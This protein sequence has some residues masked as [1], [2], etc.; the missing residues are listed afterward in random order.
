MRDLDLL[1]DFEFRIERD[2]FVSLHSLAQGI[3]DGGVDCR[4]SIPKL[5]Q[6]TDTRCMLDTPPFSDV[7][8]LGKEVAGKHCLHKPDRA[9]PCQF[10]HAQARCKTLDP[11][12]LAQ[13]DGGE[14]LA[15]R[16]STQAKPERSV[17]WKNLRLRL[18]HRARIFQSLPSH[19]NFST[20]ALSPA[21]PVELDSAEIAGR[22]FQVINF[23]Q[24][25]SRSTIFPRK[26][27]GISSRGD[28]HNHGR[29]KVIRRRK[30][31]CLNSYLLR[32]FPIIVSFYDRAVLV[33]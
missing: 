7:V 31:C 21:I 27:S 29:L 15:L 14:M 33:H 10:A 22:L 8:E 13:S 6:T 24:T 9:S 20:P 16:L 28:G 32:V 19:A 3:D 2:Q 17:G 12:L 23:N 1:A 11:M 26:N 18:G 5:N 25:Y 4:Q 30:P